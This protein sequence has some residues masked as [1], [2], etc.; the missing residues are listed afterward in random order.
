M[1]RE[2]KWWV[3]LALLGALGLAAWWAAGPFILADVADQRA[4]VVHGS[5][6]PRCW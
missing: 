6:Q 3:A 5:R 2:A 4:V 1:R